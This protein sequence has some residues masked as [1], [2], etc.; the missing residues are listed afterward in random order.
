VVLVSE[1]LPAESSPQPESARRATSPSGCRMDR[2]VWIGVRSIVI[3]FVDT[4]CGRV[5]DAANAVIQALN[6]ELRSAQRC[7]RFC[8]RSSQDVAHWSR[9]IPAHGLVTGQTAGLIR[10]RAGGGAN[11]AHADTRRGWRIR[12]GGREVGASRAP[13]FDLL[14]RGRRSR[15]ATCGDRR[16]DK[17]DKDRSWEVGWAS[18][19]GLNR[20]TARAQRN[21]IPCEGSKPDF[22]HGVDMADSL[23]GRP[24][25]R[26]RSRPERPAPPW[27]GF[28]ASAVGVAAMDLQEG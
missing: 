25:R 4:L 9:F 28:D 7:W 8:R 11:D 14:W 6:L 15:T 27:S 18:H 16:R 26:K 20:P 1:S 19:C 21:S 22:G 24:C 2:D 5:A 17:G 10:I 3:P 23:C 12:G 13:A